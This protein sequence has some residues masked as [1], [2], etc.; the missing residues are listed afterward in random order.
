VNLCKVMDE[1][2]LLRKGGLCISHKCLAGDQRNL[3]I[4]CVSS[5]YQ[6]ILMLCMLVDQYECDFL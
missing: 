5:I 3:S 4:I 2:I 6:M 1:C